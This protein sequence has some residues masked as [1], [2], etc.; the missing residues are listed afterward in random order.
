M[1]FYLIIASLLFIGI[2]VLFGSH[3]L[4]YFSIIHFF[5]IT[6]KTDARILLAIIAFLSFS[7]ILSSII[8]HVKENSFTRSF[9]FI[10]GFWMGLLVNLVLA[11]FAIWIIIFI[12]KTAGY[13]INFGLLAIFFFFLAFLYSIYGVWNALNPKIKHISVAIPN[14][15]TIWKNKK[16]VQLSDLHIGHIH[17][18]NFLSPIIEKVNAIN[19][20]MVVITGDL[21]D[22]M[23]GNFDPPLKIVDEMNPEKG[24]FFVTGNHETF[25][26][27]KIIF[28]ALEKTKVKVLHD[29]VL[30]IDGLKL[31]GINYPEHNEIKDPVKII[32][33]LK[34]LFHGKPNIFLHHTPVNIHKFKNSGVNLMLS[35]HTHQGQIFPFHLVTKLMFKSF[36]YGLHTLDEFTIYITSGAGTWGPT[37]RTGNSPEIVVIT[38]S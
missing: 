26:N 22:G 10:S 21:F 13:A 6:D 37:M 19:P 2:G 11:T 15:P 17:K 36:D 3:Y 30:D 4:L 9:Y 27:T 34:P 12:S 28:S 23:D 7:F 32:E 25:L 24:V 8:A 31:I 35:G 38:L 29:E 5:S 16:I 33:D 18:N 1:T 20:D 14:L